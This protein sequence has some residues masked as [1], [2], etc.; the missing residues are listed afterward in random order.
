MTLLPRS[1]YELGDPLAEALARQEH[2]EHMTALAKGQRCLLIADAVIS[3]LD[4]LA[5]LRVEADARRVVFHTLANLLY[6]PDT[7]IDVPDFQS[8]E[9]L[10]RFRQ[11]RP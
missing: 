3:G 8:R 7:P 4:A 5:L 11:G 1:H 9:S 2:R 6:T 10:E